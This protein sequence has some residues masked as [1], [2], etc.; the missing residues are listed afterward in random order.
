MSANE[1]IINGFKELLIDKYYDKITVA[2]ICEKANVSRKTFY[3]HF[4]DKNAILENIIFEDTVHPANELRRMLRSENLKSASRLITEMIYKNIY[5]NR[6]FYLKLFAHGGETLFVT[7]AAKLINDQNTHILSQTKLS[8]IERE[9]M[10]YFY[11]MSNVM[12]IRKWIRNKFDLTT[13]QLSRY[14]DT[15]ALSQW[16]SATNS[17]GKKK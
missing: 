17:V 4:Q 1:A 14:F 2:D 5:D 10:A 9:Y 16:Q 13:S 6:E 15:W 12:L 3:A 11:S 7:L 8:D